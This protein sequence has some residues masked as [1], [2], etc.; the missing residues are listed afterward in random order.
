MAPRIYQITQHHITGDLKL[1][2]KEFIL[3]SFPLDCRS[4]L[5]CTYVICPPCAVPFQ[6][7]QNPDRVQWH[8]NPGPQARHIPAEGELSGAQHGAAW[9]LWKSDVSPY[10]T[11]EF[12]SEIVCKPPPSLRVHIAKCCHILTCLRSWALLEKPP[13]V[14]LLQQLPSILWNLK[15]HYRVHRSP[16]LSQ[17][18]PVHTTPFYLSNIYFNIVRPPTSWPS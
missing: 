5:S 13:I 12:E 17:I 3:S 10:R 1:N 9:L 14:Q 8:A 18:D 2:L 6:L 7:R 11:V 16:I 4:V 15:V